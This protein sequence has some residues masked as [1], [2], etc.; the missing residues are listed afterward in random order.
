VRSEKEMKEMTMGKPTA[1]LG[2]LD[3]FEAKAKR[4]VEDLICAAGCSGDVEVTLVDKRKKHV[5]VWLASKT[6]GREGMLTLCYGT[7]SKESAGNRMRGKDLRQIKALVTGGGATRVMGPGGAAV[8]RWG[9]AGAWS[10]DL[11]A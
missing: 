11:A 4:Y 8:N 2:L 1:Q 3:K 7:H 9:L 6:T 5:Q 10:L